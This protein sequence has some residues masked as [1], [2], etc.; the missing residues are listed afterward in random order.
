[1]IPEDNI[2]KH[3]VLIN[4]SIVPKACCRTGQKHINQRLIQTHNHINTVV[5]LTKIDA[6]VAKDEDQQN[7]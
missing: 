6:S 5:T 4:S 7:P 2:T 3:E 1:M